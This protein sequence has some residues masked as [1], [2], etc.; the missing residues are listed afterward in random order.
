[1]KPILVYAEEKDGKIE[2]TKTEL[3][4]IV[5]EAY[6]EGKQDGHYTY[7]TPSPITITPTWEDTTTPITAPSWRDG[8]STT[9]K[10]DGTELS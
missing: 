6:R 10:A 1:M 8:W 4:R 9:C 5:D 2:I 7:S 3:Q